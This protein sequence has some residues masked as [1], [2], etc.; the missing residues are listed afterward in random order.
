MHAINSDHKCV[1]NG[2]KIVFDFRTNDWLKLN[3]FIFMAKAQLLQWTILEWVR[4]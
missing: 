2:S 1:I 4:K 3:N